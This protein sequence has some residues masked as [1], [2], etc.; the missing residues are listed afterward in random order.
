MCSPW[1]TRSTSAR[2]LASSAPVDLRAVH[3]HVPVRD[4]PLGRSSRGSRGERRVY[5]ELREA[6]YT[7]GRAEY[8]QLTAIPTFTDFV[9]L[10]MA[11]GSKRQRNAVAIG[12]SDPGVVALSTRWLRRFSR[13]PVRFALQYHADQDLAELTHFWAGVVGVDPSEIALQRKSN[14]NQLRRRTWRSRY[15]V[16]TVRA[17]DTLFRSR[18][19]AWMDCLRQSW[20]HS[21]DVGA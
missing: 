20:L 18:L 6:A 10:Y 8:A 7:Q 5:R 9:C 3:A 2:R 21:A 15:G 4:L 17:C 16:L 19:Q 14:S 11:E 13:N 1:R 12:N